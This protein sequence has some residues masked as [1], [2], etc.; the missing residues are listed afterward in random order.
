MYYAAEKD[1]VKFA[2]LGREIFGIEEDNNL[3]AG[4]EGINRLKGWFTAIGSPVSLGE[5]N[6]S[7]EDIEKIAGN[8]YT[9]AQVWG[10]RDY[11][12]EVI[13]DILNRCK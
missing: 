1:P 12:E 6:I 13:V 7:G 5:A 8:A 10:L 3:K 9:L 11:T 2:R 4:I